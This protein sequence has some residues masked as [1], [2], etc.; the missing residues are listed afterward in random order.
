MYRSN[1]IGLVL[2]LVLAISF[3]AGAQ[4]DSTLLEK[5]IYTEETLGNLDEAIK[6]YQQVVAN[7][8]A[9]RSTAALALYRLGMCFRK[10]G[11]QEKAQA[12]FDKLTKLY[13]EQKDL[14]SKI[15]VP[16]VSDLLQSATWADGELLQFQWNLSTFQWSSAGSIEKEGKGLWQFDE[17]VPYFLSTQYESTLVHAQNFLPISSRK[18]SESNS[19]DIQIKFAAD[20]I[21]I[22]TFQNNTFIRREILTDR[23]VYEEYGLGYLIRCLPLSDGFRVTIPVFSE[24]SEAVG[25]ATIE[26]IGREVITVPAGRFDCYKVLISNRANNSP[27]VNVWLSADNHRYPIRIQSGSNIGQL[28]SIKT[29]NKSQQ[30]VFDDREIGIQLSAPAGW[31]I[32]KTNIETAPIISIIGPEGEADGFLQITPI[33]KLKV[34]NASPPTV[35]EALGKLGEIIYKSYAV[36]PEVEKASPTTVL[37]ALGKANE[38]IH[39]NRAV[40]P[41]SGDDTP[42]S[43]MPTARGIADTKSTVGG[44]DIVQYGIVFMNETKACI[45]GFQTAKG[46]FDDMKPIID[47]ILNSIKIN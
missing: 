30:A 20:Q 28:Y 7:T 25:M 21:E 42:I 23:P 11:Q 13:P 39:K 29:W 17:I 34:E 31:R 19:T 5:G 26:V 3:N 22:S 33:S 1:R 37:E 32:L 35:L 45:A 16:S 40:R 27:N 47:S 38:I 9:S 14:I 8:N 43:G 46:S 18:R 41:E 4:S 12:N 24:G 44:N 15:P 6:I 36:R 10:S 2:V